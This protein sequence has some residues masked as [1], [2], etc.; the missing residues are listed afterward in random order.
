[1]GLSVA[2]AALLGACADKAQTAGAG[3]NKADSQPWDSSASA[4][5]APGYKAGD[6]ATWE[7]QLRTRAQAQNDYAVAK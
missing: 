2:L 5:N 6:K 7:Q 4:Y 1:V 3:S